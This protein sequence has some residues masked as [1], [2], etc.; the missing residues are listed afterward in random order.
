MFLLISSLMILSCAVT[1][2]QDTVAVKYDTV[3]VG[4]MIIVRKN[5]KHKSIDVSRRRDNN[6]YTIRRR[7]SNPNVSTN[8]WIFDL[9]VN[10]F[11]D[12]TNY[13]S[14]EAQ[15]F[16]AN[17]NGTPLSKNDFALRSGKSVNVNIW[18]F[19]Q[20]L[21]LI[22]HAVNLKYG[23]GLELYNFRYRR[24]ISYRDGLPSP[25]VIRD[26]L[27]FSKNKLAADYITIPVMLNFNTSP[28]SGRRGLSM[29]VGMSAGYLYGARNKQISE[30][31]GKRK[32]RNEFNLERWKLAYVAELGLGPVR[33]YGSY[34]IT[35][36][37]ETALR[38][39]PYAAGIRFSN[40]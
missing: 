28:R 18:F 15:S 6:D 11:R 23:L 21:N 10:N 31:Q 26:S 22:K 27:S 9:G 40:W 12:E 32:G 1:A 13:A 20:K 30:E 36:L 5:G 37:H 29:S 24:N 2:Q 19:M 4:G 39:Y 3:R 16:L 25:Y 8:W 7:R 34:A 33:L 38:Q 35:P 17:P 14:P